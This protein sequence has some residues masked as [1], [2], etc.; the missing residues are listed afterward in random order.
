MILNLFSGGKVLSLTYMSY[1]RK[2]P[3]RDIES[4]GKNGESVL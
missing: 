2:K 3:S 1:F 4:A